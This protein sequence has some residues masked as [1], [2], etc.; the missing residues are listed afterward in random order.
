MCSQNGSQGTGK[1][2]A[3][4]ST[5]RGLVARHVAWHR[6]GHS[7][8]LAVCL[9]WPGQCVGTGKRCQRWGQLCRGAAVQGCLCNAGGQ[10]HC[11]SGVGTGTGRAPSACHVPD[12]S[13]REW[14]GTLCL[15]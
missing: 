1:L 12:W 11:S 10:R 14:E 8:G 5:D 15:Q 9:A 7:V 4:R 6:R 3:K 2:V 13:G